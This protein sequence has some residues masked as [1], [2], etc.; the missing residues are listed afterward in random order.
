MLVAIPAEINLGA[1]LITSSHP[2][3]IKIKNTSQTESFTPTIQVGCHGCTQAHLINTTIQ[4]GQ[5][6]TMKVVFTP[7][8]HGQQSKSISLHYAPFGLSTQSLKVWFH[9]N[10]L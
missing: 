6:T 4:P 1:I 7:K 9:V 2:F 3:E 8:A 5:I 10:V